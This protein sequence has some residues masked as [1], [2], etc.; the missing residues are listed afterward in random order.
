[1]APPRSI[2]FLGI[3]AYDLQLLCGREL[4]AA[5][6]VYIRSRAANAAAYH[7]HQTWH[8][9]NPLQLANQTGHRVWHN[10]QYPR[11]TK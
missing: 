3:P 4:F 11:H 2:A 7:T 6:P 5:A 1:M 9:S 8:I 10:L